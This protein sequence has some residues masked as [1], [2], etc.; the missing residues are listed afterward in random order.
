MTQAELVELLQAAAPG[1]RVE[2]GKDPWHGDHAVA[3]FPDAEAVQV[4]YLFNPDGEIALAFYPAD[5]LTQARVFYKDDARVKNTLEFGKGDWAV[6]PNFHWGF[7]EKGLSW[8]KSRLDVRDYA[9][10]WRARISTLEE[11]ERD[12]W[13]RE[14]QRLVRDGIFDPD[15]LDQFARDFTDTERKKASPRPGLS[16]S[17]AWP[18]DETLEPEFPSIL[19][20]ALRTALAAFGE[21]RSLRALERS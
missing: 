7:W 4:A 5:T 15:D 14:L 13:E 21:H 16:V 9:D 12:Q 17:R 19:R 10:Y 3:D 2:A 6:K 8:S 20:G 18:L 1:L 11:I